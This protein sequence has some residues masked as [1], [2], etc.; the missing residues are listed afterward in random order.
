MTFLAEMATTAA[1][2]SWVI[3]CGTYIRWRQALRKQGRERMVDNNARAKGQPYLAAFALFASTLLCISPSKFRLMTVG[4]SGYKAF[5]RSRSFWGLYTF[6]WGYSLAPYAVF[7]GLL[8]L[9]ALRMVR[10]RLLD[11]HWNLRVPKLGQADITSGT[12]GPYREPE[13][14]SWE[15]KLDE[16]LNH[17]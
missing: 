3:I 10:Y 2:A 12:T 8:L 11:G 13:M 5:T 14:S 17:I 16:L 6:D 4:L 1:L 7:A 15:R 9:I